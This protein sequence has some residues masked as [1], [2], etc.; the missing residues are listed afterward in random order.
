M[1]SPQSNR[2]SEPLINITKRKTGKDY[3]RSLNELAGT[4][5]FQEWV[6]NEFPSTADDVMSG[7]S[8]RN[9]LKLMAAS[10]GLAGLTACRR[11]VEKILPNT[12]NVEGFVPGRP[13]YY[14]T[15]VSMGGAA[16]GLLVE[17]NDF[18]PTKVEGNPDHPFSLGSTNAWQQASILGLYDPDRLRAPVAEGKDSNWAA[19]DEWF[20]QNFDRAKLGDGSGLRVLSERVASPS[21]LV[22]RAQFLQ[23]F[24]KA[25]WVEYNAVSA[26]NNAGG[27]RM[28]FGQ[29]VT[30]IY[31]LEKA[32]IVLSLDSDF[33]YLDA[34]GTVL[35][36]KQ[37]ARR[38]KR[39]A[40]LKEGDLNRLYVV[41]GQYSVTGGNADHRLRMRP[42]E[43]AGFAADLAGRLGVGGNQLQV[44][45]GGTGGGDKRSRWLNVLV[46]ELNSHR[47]RCLVIAG[48]RQPAIVHAIAFQINQALGNAGS[49]V[50]YIPTQSVD[51]TAQVDR[52]KELAG[53][54]ASGAVRQLL[55]LGADPVYTAPA[56][57]DLGANIKKVPASLYLSLENDETAEAAKFSI[58]QAH[59]LESWGDVTAPD[60]TVT[61]QQPMIEPLFGGRTAA[62]V[63]AMVSGYK[64]QKAHD[65]VK[66]FWFAKWGGTPSEPAILAQGTAPSP[67]GQPVGPTDVVR[68]SLSPT[69]K[70]WRKA[71]H[72][73]VVPDTAIKPITPAI[74]QAKLNEQALSLPRGGQLEL[75]FVPDAKVYDGRFANNGWL[76]ELPDPMTKLT[77]D[78]AA[79][80]SPRTAK[81][82]NLDFGDVVS[83]ERGSRKVEA[84]VI[85]QPGQADG[86][87]VLALG[88]GRT[89][90]GNVGNNVGANAYKIRTTDAMHIA[91]DV[92]LVK[93]G[94]KHPLSLTEEQNIIHDLG[95]EAVQNRAAHL[96]READI[97]EYRKEPQVIKEMVEVPH[98]IQLYETP[99]DY[100]KGMQ[101]GMAIDLTACTGCNACV[102]ACQAENN[103]PI[104]GK[105]QVARGRAMHWIRLDRYYK[106]D[107]EDPQA[108]SQPVNCMQCE[109][110]PCENVCPVAATVH[111]PEGLNDMTYNRCVGT[112]YCSNNC[113]YKVRRFNFLNWHEGITDLGKMVMNPDVTVRMRG[114]M[115]KCTYCVQ[116]IQEAKIY[117]SPEEKHWL[118]DG[119][120]T[121]ACAQACPSEAIVFGNV[122][123]PN[124]RVAKLKKLD[125]N[126]G[127]LEEL[128]VRPRTTYLARLRNPNPELEAHN[129]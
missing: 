64:D 31:D 30:P 32:D 78:N 10:F 27:A 50:T 111:S 24:P 52:M 54:M 46:K 124:S 66:N 107:Q 37:F 104:V 121:P 29:H 70:A 13:M 1:S 97:E 68:A 63:V 16:T 117:A 22:I 25:K 35:P 11:P 95:A 28:A 73:G 57:L 45:G 43:V 47:G 65:I 90:V 83:I 75:L 36:A 71:L 6:R 60:G 123:D 110:A 53:E 119:T 86:L 81:S 102:T 49:T 21:M 67:A 23:T 33:L 100:S 58:P 129:G 19:F 115:E 80:L 4:A 59:F 127:M 39:N 44:L 76:Q 128:N 89:R 112:R 98:P 99:A 113:P 41:E 3:W 69:E 109:N 62:E 101:W 96:V 51:A 87:V 125:R 122:N 116:R 114:V 15:A 85:I 92:R 118:K 61:I 106:G 14:A 103:I 40:D 55:I 17:V 8:R 120:V 38:R 18:R 48:P 34:G 108:V 74:N 12:K 79:L 77:W 93:T 2:M 7:A 5:K 88:Y 82:L 126:Y 20:K 42:S 84:P 72:D 91:T 94:R 56:D 26:D 105:D 9:V